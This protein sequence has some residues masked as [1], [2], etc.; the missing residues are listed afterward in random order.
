[1]ISGLWA[2]AGIGLAGMVPVGCVEMRG[3]R[4][5]EGFCGRFICGSEGLCGRFMWCQGS[6][7]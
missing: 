7:A 1:M 2:V 3:L 5:S 6:G 4:G